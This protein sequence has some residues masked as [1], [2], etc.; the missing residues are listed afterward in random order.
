MQYI[1]DGEAQL[2]ITVALCD[3]LLERYFL[4]LRLYWSTRL[5]RS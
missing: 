3:E 2:R 1:L 5:K 4:L